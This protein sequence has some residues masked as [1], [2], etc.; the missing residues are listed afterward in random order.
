MLAKQVLTDQQGIPMGVFIPMQTWKN[1]LVQY[2]DI[3]TF[4]AEI[5]QWEKDF[6][7]ERLSMTQQHPERLQPIERLF[8]ML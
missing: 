4:D 7:D 1:V 8:E 3:D 6:I 5:P 2:P